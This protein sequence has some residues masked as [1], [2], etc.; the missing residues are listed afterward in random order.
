M[1]YAHL[2]ERLGNSM[3]LDLCHKCGLKRDSVRKM[4]KAGDTIP[5]ELLQC[6]LREL[7][8]HSDLTAEVRQEI[9]DEL[10]RAMRAEDEG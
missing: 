2:R 9:T 3:V 1:T 8:A 5:N 4:A 6:N 10:A 7:E